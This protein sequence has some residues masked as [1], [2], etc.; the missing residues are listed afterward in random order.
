MGAGPRDVTGVLVTHAHLDHHGLA[1][2]VRE[3]SGCWVAM[4]PAEQQALRGQ[5]NRNPGSQAW[6]DWRTAAGIP[7][8]PSADAPSRWASP[9]MTGLVDLEADLFLDHGD[10]AHVPGRD[11][12]A[13]WTPGHTPGHLCFVSPDDDVILT[14]DH[15][16]PRIT[17]NISSYVYGTPDPLGDYLDSLTLLPQHDAFEALP[18]HEYRFRGIAARAAAMRVH[19][20]RRLAEIHGQVVNAPGSTAWEIASHITWSRGWE[21]YS[22]FLLAGAVGETLSHLQYLESRGVVRGEGGSPVH[23]FH[24]PDPVALNRLWADLPGE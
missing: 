20:A 10:S 17:P 23:W 3:E 6:R 24:R 5:A 22:G 1:S 8:D 7:P 15:L 4:H 21:E 19:H 9:A 13:L 2:R 14:G 12:R 18:G 16:L 11:V